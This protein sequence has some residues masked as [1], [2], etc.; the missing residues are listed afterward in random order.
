MGLPQA[1]GLQLVVAAVALQ[2]SLPARSV[3]KGPRFLEGPHRQE[4]RRP[5]WLELQL[6][7][8]LSRVPR[9]RWGGWAGSLGAGLAAAVAAAAV[10]AAA[11]AS[12]GSVAAAPSSLHTS[13][14]PCGRLAGRPGAAASDIPAAGTSGNCYRVPEDVGKLPDPLLLLKE[15]N[16][17]LVFPQDSTM[18]FLCP[19]RDGDH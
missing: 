10:A 7:R 12:A 2:L 9:P 19:P 15:P 6:D 18:C 11:A 13:A 5:H 16:L 1:E 17:M 8:G 14:A 3:Q 4:E